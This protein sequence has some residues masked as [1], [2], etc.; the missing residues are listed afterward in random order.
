MRALAPVKEQ[1]EISRDAHHTVVE[2][3]LAPGAGASAQIL[4]GGN[5]Y[6][7][8]SSTFENRFGQIKARGVLAIDGG[9]TPTNVGATM[10]RTHTFDGTWRTYGGQTVSY[11]EP[12]MS[13]A[14]GL[15]AGI[16]EGGQGVSISGRSFS[17]VDVTAGTVGNIRDAVNVIGSGFT[18]G[19]AVGSHVTASAGAAGSVGGYIAAGTGP[20]GSAAVLVSASGGAGAASQGQVSGSAIGAQTDLSGT[21]AA[22]G[23]NG[24][25]NP[26]DRAAASGKSNQ[27]HAG[28]LVNDS[29][30]AN[31][32]AASGG[33]STSG[34]NNSLAANG[35]VG[36]SGATNN[37]HLNGALTSAKN[38]SY[39]G[40]IA[41]GAGPSASQQAGSVQATETGGVTKVSPSGLF[42]RNPDAGGIYLYETRP[43]F[44]NQQ[45]W[46]SSDYLLKQ[47]AYDPATTQKRLGDGFY[48]QRL[49]REQLAEL[50]GHSSY[51][52]ASDDSTYQQ[53]LTNAV[54]VAKEFGLRPGVALSA[55]QVSHLTSD[56]VWMESQNVM[57]PDG[58]VETV[59]VPKVYLAHVGKEALQAGGALVTGKGV[60][61][62]TMES[63]VNSGGVIDGGN[64]RTLM[65]AGQ[66]IVNRGGSIKGDSIALVA[67]RDVKNE[68]LAVTEK[69]DFG[70]NGGSYTSLSN[71]ANIKAAGT[72]DIMAGRDLGDLA[73]KIT[74]GS[75][76]L[77]A[78][79]NIDFG[80]IQTGSTY[81][82]Q[83]SG[84]TEKDNS[85]THQLSQ[86]STGGDLKIA[87]TGNLNLNGTQIAIGTVGSG[88]GQLLAGGTINIA[89][90]TNETNTSVQNDPSSK[91]YDKQVH[92][93]QTLVGAGVA[94]TGGLTVGA[95][96]LEKGA[97]N[98]TA[99]SITAGDALKLTASDSVNIV[100][101][102]EQHLSDTALTRTSSSFL[103]S[104]TT[105]QADYVATSQAIGSTLSGKTVDISAGKDINVLGSAIA[106]DGDVSLAAVGSVNIGAST[107]TLTEQHHSQVKES[108]FLSGNGF[109]FSIGTRTTT[110]DQS[111]DATTQSGQSRSMVGSLGGN[112]SIVAGDAIKVSGSDLAAGV[113][114]SLDGRSVTIDPGLDKSQGKFTQSIVQDGLT[115]AIGGSVV[116]AIQ[117]FQGM[118][119]AASQ[120]KDTRTKALAA[121]V[122][123]MTAKDTVDDIAK[124]GPSLK[125]S[126]TVGH[127]E[128]ESMEVTAGSTHSGS[129]LTAGNNVAIRAA[130][131]GTASN[132]DIVGS[133][134]RASGNVLLAADNKINLLAAQD[135]ESQH[136][137]SKSMSASVGVA[138]ELSSSAPKYGF[139]ASASVSRGNIDGEG[140]TQANSHIIAGDRLTIASGGDTNLKGAVA[141]GNQVVAEIKGNLNIESLQDTAT[142]DG[143]RQ[144][145]SVSGTVGAGAGFSGSVSQ[146]KVHNDYASVQE[147][148]GIRAGDGGFQ[149]QVAGNTD[150]KGGVISSSEQASKDGRNSISTA[151]LSFSDIENRDSSKASGVSLG[152]NVGKN[153]NGGTFSPNMAPGLGQVSSSQSSVTHSGISDAMLT[154]TDQ[155]SGQAVVNLNRDVSTGKDSAQALTKGWAGAQALD[156][157]E[158]QMQ[159]TSAALPRLAKEIGDYAERKVAELNKQ[160]N[161]EEAAKWAEGGIYRIAAHAALGAMGG[162]L[163]GALG[164]TA[165]AEVAPALKE[166][167]H[168]LQ[169]KL[170]SVGVSAGATD[171]AA[172]LIAGGAAATIGSMA[173][174]G[175]GAVTGLNVDINN[176][177]LHPEEQQRIKQLANGNSVKEARLTAAACALVKCYA[178]F[179]VDS[180]AYQNLKKIAEFGSSPALLAEREQLAQQQDL[181]RYTTTGF[182]SDKNKD[183]TKQFNNTY[184]ITTRTLG[185][186]QTVLGGLGVLGSVL[187]APAS[188]ATGI[189]CVANAGIATLS[190]D[191]MYAGSKQVV[192]GNPESTFTNK[193]LQTLGLSP[194]AASWA[195]AAI[196]VGA[197]AK[198]ASVA[199][200]VVDQSI[201]V[202]RLNAATYHEFTPNGIVPTPEIMGTPQAQSLIKE[203]QGGSAGLS[204]AAAKNI[205]QEIIQ[206]GANLLRPEG[207]STGNVLM[208]VVPK[209]AGVSEF[210][211]Y[212]MT[213]EQARIIANSTPEQAAQILGLPA[214]QAG[215]MLKNGMDFFAISPKSG[216]QPTI[217]VSNIAKTTQGTYATAPTAQ[218]VI[219]PNRSLW[220]TATPVDPATLRK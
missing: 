38:E 36:E 122:V 3:Q 88:T 5:M 59:L 81:Q 119:S 87:A 102:Q 165:V 85:I 58:S 30:Y 55:E 141:S 103:K 77:T 200:K 29:G 52:G 196:G 179:P 7:N 82:S 47:L 73:G 48:E 128:S 188:C 56:I 201:A 210:S 74:A 115:F 218:Q 142:I 162:G 79:R 27:L 84:Y 172:K 144:S 95:G 72:L 163:D 133:D 219:V 35:A 28:G 202:S 175:T 190:L 206:S 12:S 16:I 8:V 14:I 83:I 173:G 157:V 184:Q 150:L 51:S 32:V 45:Q 177:Q 34:T 194:E 94:A 135:T 153:Q 145:A 91:Q 137:Q 171:V 193:G 187:T 174:S 57:L 43:Q 20:D 160:G 181:F 101:A 49:V 147:Q 216:M 111:R 62:D 113:N 182:F 10:Y 139:T 1:L 69:Y 156:E 166:L 117:T 168:S 116:N 217:F 26:V 140:T 80:T 129:V 46:T 15:A 124:N 146:S 96:I 64:G 50:T 212:W 17:N 105:Q 131:G 31:D 18:G 149:V 109:S 138:A 199:N 33:V 164:A 114:M 178:E 208:K 127:S 76:N 22:S 53:L 167:Q 132:I 93:N 161:A 213:V 9:V 169:D 183:A 110:T 215:Q 86:V 136:S 120:S 71:Q 42:I 155:Q 205:A 63:I 65:V 24:G 204:D 37:G 123:A 108:G 11:Q 13:E 6:L 191:A 185:A 148:S 25:L 180:D 92:Q 100:S 126:L 90:V 176:R 61:I 19:G 44:A 207:S 203:I 154:V 151:T 143:K 66:D 68:S 170:T 4:A 75:A 2:D 220:T 23:G 112:L 118:T 67:D 97:I 125:V 39:L 158:A 189:G 78:G 60:T 89:A 104:K 130:G 198:A 41:I 192:S 195:E 159:I 211:P 121:A 152:V 54:S 214:A 99:S 21:V 186:G 107:S 98:I 70:Q 134:V 197:A 106:G 40:N 209:G